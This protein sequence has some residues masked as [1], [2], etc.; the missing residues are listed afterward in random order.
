M[1]GTYLGPCVS[2]V[3]G[4]R[5]DSRVFIRSM[6]IYILELPVMQMLVLPRNDEFNVAV[7][8]YQERRPHLIKSP[9]PSTLSPT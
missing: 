1:M 4:Q 2:I 6:V 5:T 7:H 9:I 8:F 3:S